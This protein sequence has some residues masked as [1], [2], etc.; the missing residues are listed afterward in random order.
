VG[1]PAGGNLVVT[2]RGG[3]GSVGRKGSSGSE[4]ESN[5]GGRGEKIMVRNSSYGG[6]KKE[7]GA[8]LDESVG[9]RQK[10]KMVPVWGGVWGNY[11]SYSR[12][13]SAITWGE[14]ERG[15]GGGPVEEKG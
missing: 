5:L 12:A 11:L 13:K 9:G 6:G 8:R 7:K 1:G 15:G 3:G 2:K 10:K 14:K 4:G